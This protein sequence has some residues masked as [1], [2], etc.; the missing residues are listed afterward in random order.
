MHNVLEK[1]LA[2]KKIEV[3]AARSIFTEKD[4]IEKISELSDARDFVAAIE[5]KHAMGH[6]SV[7]AEIKKASPSKGIIRANFNPQ[8]ST[9]SAAVSIIGELSTTSPEGG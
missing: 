4:L 1:I 6:S 5:S 3:A 2:T 9:N 8:A 7:I